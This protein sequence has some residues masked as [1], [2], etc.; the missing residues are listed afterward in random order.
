[1]ISVLGDGLMRMIQLKT[2]EKYRNHTVITLQSTEYC[3]GHRKWLT[4]KTVVKF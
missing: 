1:M 2:K 3:R 4:W